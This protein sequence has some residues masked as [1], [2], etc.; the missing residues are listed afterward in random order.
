MTT[1]TPAE[2]INSASNGHNLPVEINYF[3]FQGAG[4]AIICPQGVSTF[5][6]TTNSDGVLPYGEVYFRSA[7]F[8][9]IRGHAYFLVKTWQT[10]IKIV[11]F[12]VATIDPFAL[13]NTAIQSNGLFEFGF[14]NIWGG[15]FL[16]LTSTNLYPAVQQLGR[17]SEPYRRFSS[18]QF[19]F[20]DQT[21]TNDLH[22]FYQVRSQ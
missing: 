1:R 14:T 22:R 19:Q 15:S 2:S 9:P 16:A 12:K 20:T 7:V 8:D 21:A 3:Q 13:T 17:C 10:K 5:N 11:K 18:G 6:V 4:R